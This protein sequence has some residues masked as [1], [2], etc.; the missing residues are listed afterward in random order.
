M[1]PCPSGARISYR[2]SRVPLASIGCLPQVGRVLRG[3][4]PGSAAGPA[5]EI[6][7][8]DPGER[9]GGPD[10]RQRPAVAEELTGRP[11]DHQRRAEEVEALRPG[12]G[13][14]QRLISVRGQQT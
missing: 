8:H 7:Y 11:L 10:I 9:T 14:T 13:Y 1:P 2:A 4:T 6:V 5:G 3:I 12:G